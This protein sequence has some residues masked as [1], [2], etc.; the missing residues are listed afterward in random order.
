MTKLLA[1]KPSEVNPGHIKCVIFGKAGSGKTWLATSF[2]SAVMIDTESGA[3]R[4]HYTRRLTSAGSAYI[5]PEDGAGQLETII[6]QIT[7]LATTKHDWHTVI[8]D[9]ISKPWL[10]AISQEQERLGERDQ[11][12]MSKKVPVA[13]MRRFIR[14]IDRVDMNVIVCAHEG[15][16]WG[17]VKGQRQEVGKIPDC[18][19]KLIYELDLSLHIRA[20][21]ATRRDAIVIKS[22]LES[23]PAGDLIPLQDNGTDV[24]YESIAERY[25]R[26]FIEASP[27]T[28]ELA[29]VEQVTKLRQLFSVLQLSDEQISKALSKRNV[30]SVEEMTSEDAGFAIIDLR[31]KLDIIENHT[32]VK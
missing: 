3:K 28:I 21:S 13:L 25:G 27:R 32:T 29:S 10:T 15:T 5:G 30:D 7:L 12:G 8:V 20:H 14:A 1:R 31:K 16:E 9:S 11:F 26:E 4:S 24:S 2:P 17:V 22:R 18:Y 6:E 19:E 23:F